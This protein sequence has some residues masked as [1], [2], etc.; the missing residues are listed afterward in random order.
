[1][2]G[3]PHRPAPR[4]PAL[5]AIVLVVLT[6][7]CGGGARSPTTSAPRP[8]EAPSGEAPRSSANSV[9]GSDMRQAGAQR[10]EE[11]LNGRVPGLQVLRDENGR[12]SLRIRGA[13]S[14]GQSDEEPLIVIDGI[15]MAQGS[16]AEVLRNIDPRDIQRIDVLKD[17]SQTAMYGSRGANGVLII[18]T[19][20]N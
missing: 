1:M 19:R 17:A 8:S 6:G 10:I 7:A 20:R 2:S 15:P 3:F 18:R 12:Y 11:Y 9:Q 5:V 13:A 4:A 14:L 16:N